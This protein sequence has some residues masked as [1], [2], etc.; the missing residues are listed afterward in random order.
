MMKAST[1]PSS[2]M[3]TNLKTLQEIVQLARARLTRNE[4]D[5]L[6]GGSD[7]ETTMKRNRLAFE[8]LALKARVM[9]DVSQ[10]YTQSNL[11]GVDLRLPVLLAPIGSLQVFDVGAGL[12]VAQAA[13][14]FGVMPIYSSVCQPDFETLMGGNL[15]PKI[16]Q[17]YVHGDEAWMMGIIG[18]A[19]ALGYKGLCLTVDTQVYSRRERDLLKRYLPMSQRSNAMLSMKP[20]ASPQPSLQPSLSWGL[21]DRI[22]AR[23]SIPLILKGI[24]CAEDAE[25]AVQHG[26]D[27]VY[28]SNHGGR[29]LDQGRATLDMLP[30]I[31]QAV[32]GRVKIVLDGGILRGT[33]VLKALALGADAVAIGRLEGLALAAGGAP[34][35]L[36]M[37]EL[38]EIEIRTNLALMG[39]S[40]IQQLNPSCLTPAEPVRPVHALSGFPLMEEGY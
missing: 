7:T 31:V 10:V 2:A 26:V 21:V 8:R 13:E 38:L 16:Y 35:V 22:K 30:E 4:W 19:Q 24:A 27:V 12:A 5:Y 37:L 33:D 15:G 18:R 32:A 39:L 29:Q 3:T 36:R 23:F 9:T 25:L 28:V 11:L 34:A 20:S 17:L 6:L 14:Q 1:H 40:S